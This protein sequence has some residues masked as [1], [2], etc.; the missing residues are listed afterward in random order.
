M[1]ER[2]KFVLEWERRWKEA[3]GGGSIRIDPLTGRSEDIPGRSGSWHPRTSLTA[4]TERVKFVLE[5][6][7]RWSEGEGLLNVAELCREFGISRHL[8]YRVIRV[9]P[10]TDQWT[11]PGRKRVLRFARGGSVPMGHPRIS[12]CSRHRHA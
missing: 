8:G 12:D 5:S 1:K 6:E 2:T 4:V 9:D 10:L 11:C 7:R 3:E